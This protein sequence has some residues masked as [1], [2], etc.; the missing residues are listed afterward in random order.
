VLVVNVVVVRP[1]SSES[2]A[3][4]TSEHSGVVE[5]CKLD[6]LGTFIGKCSHECPR[7]LLSDGEGDGPADDE[8]ASGLWLY[9]L[10]SSSA[11]GKLDFGV[12]DLDDLLSDPPNDDDVSRIDGSSLDMLAV[13]VDSWGNELVDLHGVES[14]LE[15]VD[16]MEEV[17]EKMELTRERVDGR[18][19]G[20]GGEGVNEVRGGGLEGSRVVVVAVAV[21]AVVE[22]KGIVL[23]CRAAASAA[24]ASSNLVRATPRS[25]ST[26]AIPD[27]L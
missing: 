24:S 6:S 16:Q 27:D 26:S 2:D 18:G 14:L 12:R 17:S 13:S 20:G 9:L 1:P 7:R 11:H 10:K 23:V 25:A 4:E 8:A 19:G 3:A 21:A 5:W 22:G 15:R